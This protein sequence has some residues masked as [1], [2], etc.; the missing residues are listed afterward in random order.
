M[1]PV[2]SREVL[3]LHGWAFVGVPQPPTQA[4]R[5]PCLWAAA[6]LRGKQPAVVQVA[7]LSTALKSPT[8][9]RCF[10]LSGLTI[11]LMLVI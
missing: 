5:A 11:E 8:S 9:P 3:F 6:Q 7:D 1:V 4:G 10:S 2:V